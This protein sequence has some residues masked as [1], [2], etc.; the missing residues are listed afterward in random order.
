M[1]DLKGLN[2]EELINYFNSI[3]EKTF[4]GKQVYQWIYFKKENDFSN[5]TNLSKDLRNRLIKE[6]SISE[7]KLLNRV[8]SKS[9][10]TEKY[11]F[12]LNDGNIIES[13]IMRYEKNLGPGR[14]TICISSQAGCALGCLFCASGCDGLVRNLTVGEIV[15]QIISSQ[16]LLAADEERIA[17]VVIMGIGEPLANY[18]NLVKAIHLIKDSHGI[19]IGKRHISISTC[20]LAPQIRR[21]AEDCDCKLAVSLHSYNDEIRSKLMPVNKKYPIKDLISACKYYQEVTDTRITFEYVLIKDI[22]DSITGAGTLAKMIKNMHCI[23][24][25][26]PLNRVPHFPYS[27]PSE[28]KCR[29]FAE[30]IEKFGVKATLRQERGQTIDGA[31]GQLRL[32]HI[33]P[34]N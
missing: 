34:E 29:K 18:D 9:R 30:E 24:N 22:N 25:I 3:G 14:V 33:N 12:E 27:P 7:I 26:I 8:V 23:V 13:V 28:A 19:G 17:N 16:R 32:R 10:N 21:L 5:M 1:I 11:L 20:G 6:A 4:R 2:E 31:C 15:D